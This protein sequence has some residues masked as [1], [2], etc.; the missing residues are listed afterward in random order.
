[1]PASPPLGL[2]KWAVLT[3]SQTGHKAQGVQGSL[4]KRVAPCEAQRE[5]LVGLAG[6][7][8]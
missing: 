2:G 8:S 5:F 3:V 7:D 4:E 6:S 1:M